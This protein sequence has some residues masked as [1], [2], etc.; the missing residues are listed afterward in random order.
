MVSGLLKDYSR[1]IPGLIKDG[2]MECFIVIRYCDC[3]NMR[4]YL[5]ILTF[6]HSVNQSLKDLLPYH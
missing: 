1:I 4:N 3:Y 2:Y 6:F 5:S